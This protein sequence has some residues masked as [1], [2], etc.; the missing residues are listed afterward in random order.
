MA[1]SAVGAV[2]AVSTIRPLGA[3]TTVVALA[4]GGKDAILNADSAGQPWWTWWTGRRPWWKG[5]LRGTRAAVSAVGAVVAACVLGTGAA[6]VAIAIRGPKWV[7]GA[8]VGTEARRRCPRRLPLAQSAVGAVSAVSTIRPL[9]ARTTVVALAV[10]GK[11]AILNADSA[12]QPWWTWWT[13][14]RPWWKGGLRGT[15][16]AVSAVGAVVAACVLGTGAA[17]VAIAIRGPKWVVGACVGTKDS[18]I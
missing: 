5:G 4:V 8:C 10:G 16:A 7:V 2:S 13:G 11:D 15:R 17:V 12:G 6:V 3:R 1:Q 14:R 9:G 18:Q